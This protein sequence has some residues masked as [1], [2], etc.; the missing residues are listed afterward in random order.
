MSNH[1]PFDPAHTCCFSG[2]RPEKLGFDW[3][4]NPDF[5][6]I[7]RRDLRDAILRAIELDYTRFITG[8]SRG[9]DLW[10]AQEVLALRRSHP[11][12][13]LIAALPF[14]GMHTH[15]T[16]DWRACFDS[17]QQACDYTAIFADA[18]L[19]GCYHARDS[20]M[21]Q[22]SS[23]VICWYNH[24]TTGGTAYTCRLAMRRGRTLDNIYQPFYQA[25]AP[26]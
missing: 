24:G 2:S 20:Y 11:T 12:L 5:F 13:E 18:Y 17:V 3:Q 22:E 7:L 14:P 21:V 25:A 6:K 8:M 15:W 1:P 4:R 19:P 9:F 26:H 23:R 16:P 10:A